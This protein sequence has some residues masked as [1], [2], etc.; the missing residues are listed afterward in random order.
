MLIRG[1]LRDL[2]RRDKPKNN[3]ETMNK[4]RFAKMTI[5]GVV[6][7]LNEDDI[8]EAVVRHHLAQMDRVIVLDDGSHDRTVEIVKNLIEEGL[9]V[10]LIERRCVIFDEANRNTFLFDHARDTFGADWV[11][12]FDADEFVDTRGI[13]SPL[14]TYLRTVEADVDGV[15]VRLVNYID[16]ETDNADEVVVPKRMVWRHTTPHDVLKVFVRANRDITINAGNHSAQRVGGTFKVIQEP[17]IVLA[18][19]PRR[20]GWHDIYKW[21][22][23]R[24]KITAAGSKEVSAGTGSHYIAPFEILMNRPADLLNSVGFFNPNPDPNIMSNNPIEYL[25][26]DLKYTHK[27]DYKM[28]CISMILKYAIELA[29]EF[30]NQMD[31]NE[32]VRNHIVSGLRIKQ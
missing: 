30:G 8:I 13:S 10:N 26:A 24:L 31:T 12:F 20:S 17:N 23:G 28:K 7:T 1:W 19:Y 32:A 6:R 27:T 5:V 11:V 18:H 25:G 2:T 3:S 16:A 4:S 9:A 29:S 21:V 14:N 15:Q 22:I